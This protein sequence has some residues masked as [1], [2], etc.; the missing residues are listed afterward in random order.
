[1]FKFKKKNDDFKVFPARVPKIKTSNA[2]RSVKGTVY[3]LTVAVLLILMVLVVF[4]VA[5]STTIFKNVGFL[6]FIFNGNWDPTNKAN[7]SYGIGTIIFMTLVLLALTM[8]FAVPIT[9]FSTLFISEYLSKRTQKMVMTIVK[10]LAG[11][12]SIVF[13][14]FAREQ[15]GWLCRMMGAPSNDNLM[16]AVITMTFMAVPTMVSLSYNAVQSVPSTYRFAAL[17]L[18]VTKEQT[19]FGIIRKSVNTKIIS[20]II[21]GMSRV[22]G[23]TMA[24]MMIAGNSVGGFDTTSGLGG[25]LFSSVRTLA[26]TIGIE[27][28]EA[29]GKD[30][31][32]ALYAIGLILFFLVF[33]INL[34]ILSLSNFETFKINRKIKHE[35][36]LAKADRIKPLKITKRYDDYQLTSFVKFHSQNKIFKNIH[37]SIML[38]L[39]WTSTAIIVMFTFW[40]IGTVAVKGLAG[41]QYS[42][43]FVSINDQGGI[44]AALFTTLL[45]IAATLLFA[46]PLGLATAIYLSEY[47]RQSSLITKSF[48]FIINLFASTP[49][50]IFGIFG[51]SFF[52]VIMKLPFSVLAAALTMTIVVLPMLISNFEDALTSVP[53]GHKESAAALGLNKMKILFKI[54]LPNAM[55]GI[56]TAILLSMAKIIGE[57]APIYL[58]L[59]TAIRMPSEGFLSTGATLTTG[60]YMIAAGGGVGESE[61][62]AYLMSLTTIILVL[63]LNLASSKLSSSILRTT[64]AIHF[65][66]IKNFIKWWKNFSLKHSWN[67]FIRTGKR[68]WNKVKFKLSKE[69]IVNKYNGSKQ[70]RANIKRIKMEDE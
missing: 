53:L 52:I 28:L 64:H 62:I 35:E 59:G 42:E 38:L 15:I 19:T 11:I 46:I 56:I 41:L 69:N 14:L 5:K 2:E 70:R 12:P 3:L 34:I 54:T 36:K 27:I 57:S 33:V 67:N 25:F 1:M 65:E 55:E 45:L 22:I 63:T 10:L 18:G 13:G 26:G 66:G 44:I 68:R 16:V 6:D 51:L 17:S 4:V 40:I 39:M 37:S 30:H 58:T 24:I 49:S 8:L 21:M 9:I 29:S 43:A 23:E 32:S 50:I 61:Y 31:Q 47:A 60:I 20:A 48:R 7:P